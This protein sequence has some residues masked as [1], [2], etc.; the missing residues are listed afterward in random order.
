MRSMISG[1]GAAL[2]FLAF[3]SGDASQ[4]LAAEGARQPAMTRQQLAQ[5]ILTDIKQTTWIT[6]GKGP[7]VVYIF[8]DPNCPYCHRLYLNTRSWVKQGKLQIHW[9]PVGILTTTSPGK[10]IALLQADDPVAA[11]YK[12]EDHYDE[13]GAIEEDLADPATEKQLKANEALLSRT[14]SGAVPVMLF[15]DL[16]GNPRLFTGSPPKAKVDKILKYVK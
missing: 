13:G 9:I 12:N 1:L 3:I 6:E 2:I 14:H 5:S 8:F 4:V 16:K 11:F 7:H 10:A 15:H